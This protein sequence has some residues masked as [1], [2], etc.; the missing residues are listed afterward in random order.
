MS[1]FQDCKYN[2]F[3]FTFFLF[4]Y[5]S[6]GLWPS[7]QVGNNSKRPWKE[8]RRYLLPPRTNRWNGCFI[9]RLQHSQWQKNIIPRKRKQELGW[10]AARPC[11]NWNS[12]WFWVASGLFY[13]LTTSVQLSGE[14]TTARPFTPKLATFKG[15]ILLPMIR[16]RD[17]DPDSESNSFLSAPKKQPIVSW[18][19][20]PEDA[21]REQPAVALLCSSHVWRVKKQTNRKVRGLREGN[22][23]GVWFS[24]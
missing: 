19:D 9:H 11:L 1:L 12:A 6:N 16:I 10:V 14:M 2:C 18:V 24:C 5:R 21:G 8:R 4:L 17:S 13:V 3:D 20:I 23:H 7:K 22:Q 15:A